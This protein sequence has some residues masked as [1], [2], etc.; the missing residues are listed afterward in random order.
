[1]SNTPAKPDDGAWEK[2]YAPRVSRGSVFFSAAIY[3]AW[4]VLLTY[5]AVNRWF[6]SFQ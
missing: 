5:I 4:I 1:M 2:T 6:G 3:A